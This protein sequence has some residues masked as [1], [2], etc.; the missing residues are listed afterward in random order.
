MMRRALFSL[1]VFL[2]A[3]QVAAKPPVT[4]LA[5]SPDGTSVLV[6]SQLGVEIRAWPNLEL[7]RTVKSKMG[8]VHDVAIAKDRIA[9]VGGEPGEFGLIEVYDWPSCTKLSH[10]IR[11]E[12]VIY[13]AAWGQFG[14]VLAT[15]ASD[16]LVMVGPPERS[17]EWRTLRGHSRGVLAVQ[18]IPRSSL[19]VT[20]G[21]DNSLRVW[22]LKTN[23]VERVL[24]N[25]RGIVRDLALRPSTE[26]LPM[27]ASVGADR[28]VRFWQPTIG[29]LVR[30]AKLSAEPLSVAWA[31]D[32]KSV[33][34]GCIDGHVRIVNL[35]DVTIAAERPVIDGWVYEVAVGP[36]GSTIAAGSE[37][38]VRCVHAIDK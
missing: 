17:E 38:Q 4:A 9:V 21:L 34:V 37:G 1:C 11:H 3:A 10:S 20:A 19:L 7:L 25:H 24:D 35:D 18:F 22:N 12:D 23:Q 36:D 13:A 2:T 29:R 16:S 14:E 26:G 28:T 8:H 5:L 33:V 31:S 27:V 15:A 6:G 30:Y 32:N